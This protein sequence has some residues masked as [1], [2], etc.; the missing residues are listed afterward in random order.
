MGQVVVRD[1]GPGSTYF[2]TA[3]FNNNQDDTM[4]LWIHSQSGTFDEGAPVAAD[5]PFLFSVNDKILVHF[6]YESLIG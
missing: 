4:E 3:I 6:Q 1:E 5:T 2:G